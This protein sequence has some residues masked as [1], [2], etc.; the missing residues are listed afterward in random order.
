[1]GLASYLA[2]LNGLYLW[3]GNDTYLRLFNYWVKIFAICFAMGVVSGIVM[4][5]Q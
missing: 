5:Y 2:V 4:S 1:I 3:K